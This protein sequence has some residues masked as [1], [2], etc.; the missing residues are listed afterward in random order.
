MNLS[1]EVASYSTASDAKD[2]GCYV[3]HVVD[4]MH[5]S[6]REAP[7][8]MEIVSELMDPPAYIGELAVASLRVVGFSAFSPLAL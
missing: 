2:H 7:L 6:W 5:E 4:R 3:T 8:E 1:H